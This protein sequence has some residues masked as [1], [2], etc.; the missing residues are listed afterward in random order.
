MN[1]TLDHVLFACDDLDE[2]T[3]TFARLGLTPD[4]GGVHEEGTTEMA[5]VGF[6]D[7]TYLE[8]IAPTDPEEPPAQWPEAMFSAGPCRWCLR[9]DD[10]QREVDRLADA[11]ATV[12]GPTESSR[13]RPDGTVVEY[14]E[15]VYGTEGT[16]WRLP[17]L[18]RDLTPRH[19]RVQQSDALAETGLTGIAEV[20]VAVADLEDAVEQFRRLHGYPAPQRTDNEA[21]GA[22]LASFPG[23]PVTLAEPLDDSTRLAERLDEF[24]P[25]PCAVLLG[26]ADFAA[27]TT[28]YPVTD[29]SEW[30]GSRLAWFDEPELEHRVGVVEQ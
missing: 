28:E 30:F 15:A 18:V 10:L 6:E 19:H 9:T 14:Q 13:E 8:L 21:F 16:F 24:Q 27:S 11:G 1:A 12:H 4:Y 2:V 17:F 7:G 22:T 29:S 25:G 26:S 23:E 3:D 20:V 5:M